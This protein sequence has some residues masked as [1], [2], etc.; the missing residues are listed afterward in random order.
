M[1]SL[2]FQFILVP[3][4]ILNFVNN[5]NAGIT[6]RFIRE[7]WPSVD[8]PLDHEVFAVPKGY[9]APQQVRFS[10]FLAVNVQSFL[11]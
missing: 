5:V 8:I 10:P 3:F 1:K 4:V 9:N 11:H 6:S 2:L 7:E